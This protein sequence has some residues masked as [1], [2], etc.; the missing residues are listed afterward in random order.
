[1]HLQNG[2]NTTRYSMHT[3]KLFYTKTPIHNESK[4]FADRS[5][6]TG[7]L[8]QRQSRRTETRLMQ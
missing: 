8:T 5:T 3:K 4:Q 2:D 7:R 6:N 1:M